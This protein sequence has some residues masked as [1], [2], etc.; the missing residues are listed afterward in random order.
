MGDDRKKEQ[1]RSGH[2][3]AVLKDGSA[4]GRSGQLESFSLAIIDRPFQAEILSEPGPGL[5]AAVPVS[6]LRVPA[7]VLS[8]PGADTE[9]VFNVIV[10]VRPSQLRKTEQRQD[11]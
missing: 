7:S 6:V 3:I 11:R 2:R 5:K 1:Q 9:C 10:V 4:E 8:R